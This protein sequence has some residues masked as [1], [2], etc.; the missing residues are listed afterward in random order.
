MHTVCI[1]MSLWDN[2]LRLNY[3]CDPC[4]TLEFMVQHSMLSVGSGWSAQCVSLLRSQKNIMMAVIYC[5]NSRFCVFEQ[6]AQATDCFTCRW[7]CLCVCFQVL[8]TFINC[9][10]VNWATRVQSIFT[11]TKVF[12]LAI[13]IIIGFIQLGKGQLPF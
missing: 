10:N 2:F 5:C 3:F 1:I 11:V 4:I 8:L 12:A 6:E 7:C 9:W 13:V